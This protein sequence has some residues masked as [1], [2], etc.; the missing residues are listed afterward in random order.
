[1]YKF[2]NEGNLSS[3]AIKKQ[4]FIKNIMLKRGLIFLDS[5]SQAPVYIS[6]R[7]RS[8]LR[9]QLRDTTAVMVDSLL[10]E[11]DSEFD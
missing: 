7:A 4:Q 1:M 2:N 3:Y 9:I 5:V 10:I 11:E 8:M 6:G